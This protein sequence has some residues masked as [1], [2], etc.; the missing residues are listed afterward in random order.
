[1]STKFDYTAQAV[2]F[3]AKFPVLNHVSI[4]TN[5]WIIANVLLAVIMHLQSLMI[6]E[7]IGI[8]VSGGLGPTVL[9]AIM[10][11]VMYGVS[12]GLADYYLDKKFLRKQSLGIGI[13][14]KAVISLTAIV[15]L[16]VLIQFVLFDLFFSPT[17]SF[18]LNHQSWRHLFHILLIYYFFMTLIISFI[19][20][21]NKKYGPGVLIPLL[22]GK[23]R[24]PR[25]EERIFLFMDLK[26]ST[27]TA[28]KLGHLKYSSF[29]SDYF[30]D[31][32]EVLLPFRAE[33]YQYVGDEIVVTWRE[34]EGLKDCTCIRFF[35]ACKKQFQD[36]TSYY[37][38]QY[39]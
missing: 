25:E 3:Y 32:N 2:R 31:I 34:N 33:V 6:S 37:M 7:A 24:N 14:L 20:Q 4:Q 39:G 36:R 8:P 1:M 23:Y 18:R 13:L 27:T 17:I 16:L 12:L 22:L 28:E 9:V 21:V 26:S 19:N 5:F 10:F 35:F 30:M 15:L 38:A 11:G 29:I